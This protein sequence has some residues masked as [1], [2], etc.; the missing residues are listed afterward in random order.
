[1]VSITCIKITLNGAVITSCFIIPAKNK[2]SSVME[3]ND[4]E[5]NDVEAR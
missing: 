1:M 3:I 2:N 5:W 4:D